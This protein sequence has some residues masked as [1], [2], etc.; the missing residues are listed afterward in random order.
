MTGVGDRGQLAPVGNLPDSLE[1][2]TIKILN[3][4]STPKNT[5]FL[6]KN[7]KISNERKIIILRKL[8]NYVVPTN[9]F[10][11]IKLLLIPPVI[12]PPLTRP[13]FHD[14]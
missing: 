10:C 4:K 3:K 5:F 8:S 6:I 13:I 7:N 1:I 14:I 11:Y 12:R 9:W 2:E